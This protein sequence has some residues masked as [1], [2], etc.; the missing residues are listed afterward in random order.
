MKSRR[1]HILCL[2][3]PIAVLGLL[4]AGLELAGPA[5]HLVYGDSVHFRKWQIPVPRIFC[6]F[7]SSSVPELWKLPIGIPRWHGPYA[8]I[9]F[10][11]LARELPD[12]FSPERYERWAK[13][14]AEN[15]ATRQKF[16]VTAE[17]KVPVDGT[18]AYC[19]ES[20]S[21]EDRTTREITCPIKGSPLVADYF[22]SL[23]YFPDF[24]SMLKG[25]SRSI[26]H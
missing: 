16:W 3:I 13:N 22:G 18:F 26:D 14:A 11:V 24:Y 21:A 12:S 4:C 5:W 9:S 25:M 17:R 7:H 6:V 20:V 23:K 15:S 1:R 19:F 10:L 2:A 8:T